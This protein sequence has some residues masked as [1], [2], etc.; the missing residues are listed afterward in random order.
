[1]GRLGTAGISHFS[2]FDQYGVLIAE[3]SLLVGCCSKGWDALTGSG[4]GSEISAVSRPSFISFLTMQ[5]SISNDLSKRPIQRGSYVY[6]GSTGI[7]A[8]LAQPT[9]RR[10]SRL[11]RFPNSWP[12]LTHGPNK[13]RFRPK[14]DQ[15]TNSFEPNKG[16]LANQLRPRTLR[17]LV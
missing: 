3:F 16:I 7:M 2:T 17:S 1:M 5:W 10:H 11:H 9:E 6:L 8:R 12:K 15:F 14:N 13:P 4:A